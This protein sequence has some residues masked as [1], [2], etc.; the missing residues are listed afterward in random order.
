MA[1]DQRI[2]LGWKWKWLSHVMGPKIAQ[3]HGYV[4]INNDKVPVTYMYSNLI[5]SPKAGAFLELCSTPLQK[6]VYQWQSHGARGSEFTFQVSSM[7]WPS[8][9][10]Q[11]C[12]TPALNCHVVKLNTKKK[13]LDG[14]QCNYKM[15]GK[16]WFIPVWSAP[17]DKF[18][19]I[20]P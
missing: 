5:H 10:F 15:S 8:V 4:H 9:P 13:A 16:L 17:R 18:N 3:G 19:T 14:S 11:T 20:I 7:H 2:S 6:F 1:T 12:Q